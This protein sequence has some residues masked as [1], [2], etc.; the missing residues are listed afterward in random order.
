MGLKGWGGTGGFGLAWLWGMLAA[1]ESWEKTLWREALAV[2]G[3][4]PARGG[5]LLAVG[6]PALMGDFPKGVL[7]EKLA[8]GAAL[9]TNPGYD[10]IVLVAAGE[11]ACVDCGLFLRQARDL[12]RADGRLVIVAARPWP[13][14]E[15]DSPWQGGL[16]T[17]RWLRLL[18]AGGWLVE[19]RP[20]V[21]FTSDRLREMLPQAGLARVLVAKPRGR[22]G[23]RVR[24]E[25]PA[26]AKP[27]MEPG[28]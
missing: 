7:V 23:S 5:L 25:V 28:F 1:M 12:L 17:R 24:A 16:S 10:R 26:L 14:G 8:W 15:R 3:V 19:A 4:L 22:G 13:W 20:T 18:R 9:T 27:L 21:G 2:E 11:G 6:E